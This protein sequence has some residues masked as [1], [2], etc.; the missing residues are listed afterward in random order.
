MNIA[1]SVEYIYHSPTIFFGVNFINLQFRA[2]TTTCT[3]SYEQIERI[4]RM[5]DKIAGKTYLP[6]IVCKSPLFKDRNKT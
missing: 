1:P 4:K 3:V 5:H 6:F 2:S